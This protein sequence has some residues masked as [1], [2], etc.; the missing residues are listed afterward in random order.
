MDIHDD[1]EDELVEAQEC[2][3]DN[4]DNIPLAT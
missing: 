3:V 4:N 2:E 1:V